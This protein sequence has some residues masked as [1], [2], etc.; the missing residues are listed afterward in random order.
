MARPLPPYGRLR[1]ARLSDLPRIGFV[2]AAGF[3]HST[4]FPFA[5]PFYDEFPADTV[6]SYRKEYRE[7]ILDS[8]KLV[9][10]AL[11]DYKEE[12]ADF[13][14]DALKG[15]YPQDL[16]SSNL[17][18]DGKIIVGIISMTLEMI[19]VRHGQFNLD[20][21]FTIETTFSTSMLI[22][23]GLE[24]P[25]LED[26]LKR[27]AFSN[28]LKTVDEAL[29]V[30][31]KQYGTWL[32]PEGACLF[33]N[34]HSSGHSEILSLG[35]HPA[36]WKKGLGHEL[37]KWCVALADTDNVPLVVSCSPMGAKVFKKF[38]FDEKQLVIIKGHK[39]HPDDITI[40]FRQRPVPTLQS[41]GG[42]VYQGI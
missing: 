16:S 19:A 28:A 38:G 4:F 24:V 3:F 18:E 41:K 39:Y 20:G 34:R 32:R 35:V 1:Q 2:A 17:I 15:I 14:Y 26:D 10:V 6:A 25:M 42:E 27:D 40:S 8:K 31:E 5:R 37:V 9:L 36:Y 12:E 30:P 13:V 7:C 33:I 23:Q 29:Q 11:D 22:A 21:S